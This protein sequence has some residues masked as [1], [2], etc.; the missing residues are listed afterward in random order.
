MASKRYWSGHILVSSK[1]F[2]TPWLSINV[3]TVFFHGHTL[4]NDPNIKPVST[5]K[6]IFLKCFS[7]YESTREKVVIPIQ[8]PAP[9]ITMIFI[10]SV[11]TASIIK[12]Y[13]PSST[14]IKLPDIPGRIIAQIAIA[15]HKKINNKFD[16]VS[17]GVA[18]VI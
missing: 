8:A 3:S 7:A 15:P 17:A 9:N 1:G 13:F 16:G 11:F 4:F 10:S 12:K 14:N 5:A 6:V 18:T 2:S